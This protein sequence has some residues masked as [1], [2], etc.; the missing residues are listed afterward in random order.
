MT[1]L[2]GNQTT[3]DETEFKNLN[4]D[5]QIIQGKEF[6]ECVFAKCSFREAEFIDC[7]FSQCTFIDCDLSVMK[8]KGSVFTETKFKN[9]KVIGVNWVEAAWKKA[10]FLNM[11]GFENCTVNYSIF[12]GLTLKDFVLKNCTALEV[13]FAESDLT[14]ANCQGTDFAKSRFMN[15]NLIEADFVDATNYSIDAR[16]NTLKKTK[17]S[18]PEAEALLHSLDIIL[19]D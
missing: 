1:E 4:Y 14:K 15:T 3:F 7:K 2:T 11:V 6:I 8:V 13:D 12:F 19:V 5:G 18:L 17:F 9:S 16:I 10:G